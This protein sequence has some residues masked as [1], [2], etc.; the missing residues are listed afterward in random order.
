[1]INFC[2]IVNFLWYCSAC[3]V[4]SPIDYANNKVYRELPRLNKI[5]TDEQI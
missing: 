5:H 4:G 3:S 2:C 1:M